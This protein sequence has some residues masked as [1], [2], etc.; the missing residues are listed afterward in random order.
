V[1]EVASQLSYD[2]DGAVHLGVDGVLRSF[3]KAGQ[4][5]SYYPLNPQRI[6]QYNSHFPLNQGERLRSMFEGTD[7]RAATDVH[8]L[9]Q[10]L[11]E[12]VPDSPGPKFKDRT[13][14]GTGTVDARGIMNA[15]KS[16]TG[17]VARR[18]ICPK[19]SAMPSRIM[20]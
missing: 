10:S 6:R 12:D 3:N 18:A 2:R 16:I 1:S 14:G 19:G 15:S 4:V 11:T 17:S 8:Q 9:L 7:G 5:L 20:H 13:G